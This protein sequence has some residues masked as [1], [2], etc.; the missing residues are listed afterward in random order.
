MDKNLLEKL[1][2]QKDII[3]PM[4]ISTQQMQV[5][6]KVLMNQRLTKTEQNYW[7]NVRKKIRVLRVLAEQEQ[8]QIFFYNA[9]HMLP[10]RK[11]EATT[12]LLELKKKGI[13]AFI[14][15]SFLFSNT[16][17]DIDVFIL[18]RRRG[19]EFVGNYHYISL[20]KNDLK[21][22]V[23]QSAAKSCVA[24]LD[25]NLPPIEQ[26]KLHL[27][28]TLGMYQEIIIAVLEQD[29]LKVV[30]SLLADY[31]YHVLGKLLDSYE[32]QR[33]YSMFLAR[34]EKL[35]MVNRLAKE[36]LLHSFNKDYL[37]IRLSKYLKTIQ[38]DIQEISLHDHLKIYEQTYQ[39]IVDECRTTT[40]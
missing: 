32:L 9:H 5:I 10:E 24:N 11:Q 8:S 33:E 13:T 19:E 23:F 4:V 7:Y 22:P 6:E 27:D 12:K 16:Y 40:K 14:S 29:D 37:I 36:L 30:K 17:N 38:K 18:T 2:Q 21:K 3:V 35:L 31:S 28:Q 20:T 26:K 39:E 25:L 1:H 15:G 34:K